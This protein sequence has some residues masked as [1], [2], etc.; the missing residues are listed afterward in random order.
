MTNEESSPD[1]N[2]AASNALPTAV[3]AASRRT[4]QLHPHEE[5]KSQAAPIKRTAVSRKAAEAEKERVAGLY[6]KRDTDRKVTPA[7]SAGQPFPGEA[8]VGVDRSHLGSNQVLREQLEEML[9]DLAGEMTQTVDLLRE[10]SK[11]DAQRLEELTA[12]R[13]RHAELQA[14]YLEV[15]ERLQDLESRGTVA[16][17]VFDRTVRHEQSVVELGN[18]LH[19]FLCDY[20]ARKE[21]A[22]NFSDLHSSLK[23][24][25]LWRVSK[26]GFFAVTSGHWARLFRLPNPTPKEVDAAIDRINDTAEQLENILDKFL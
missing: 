16:Q 22:D 5:K 4:N 19:K 7:P 10:E 12:L 23:N 15:S 1:N 24:Q 13:E 25:V 17:E 26:Q 9:D 20:F 18:S 3:E 2:E 11:L 6:A 21:G 8:V 14:E